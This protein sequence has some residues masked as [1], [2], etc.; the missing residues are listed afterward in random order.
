M[1]LEDTLAQTFSCWL[2][3]SSEDKTF[4]RFERWQKL[5]MGEER[6][7][8]KITTRFAIFVVEVLSFL[9]IQEREFW[10]YCGY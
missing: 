6:T 1:A 2:P 9:D 8:M 5:F 3:K 7:T 4:R 10:Q